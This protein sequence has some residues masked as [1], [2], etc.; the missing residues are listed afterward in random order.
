M[1]EKKRLKIRNN[2]GLHGR[3]A[4]RIVELAGQY[5]SD[6]Y[7]QKDDHEVDGESILSI[8]TLDCPKGTELNVSAEGDDAKE[9]MDSLSDLFEQ[10]FGENK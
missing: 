5:R 7:F 3:A 10:K 2:L 6:L 1:K 8:L 9:L 4:A